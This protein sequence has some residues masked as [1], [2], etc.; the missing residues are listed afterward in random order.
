MITVILK[1][2]ICVFY[3]L[4]LVIFHMT[5]NFLIQKCIFRFLRLFGL[6]QVSPGLNKQTQKSIYLFEKMLVHYGM[7]DNSSRYYVLVIV[8]IILNRLTSANLKKRHLIFRIFQ[9][10]FYQPTYNQKIKRKKSR[11]SMDEP[12]LIKPQNNCFGWTRN[13]GRLITDLPC[14]VGQQNS[15]R[16]FVHSFCYL[17]PCRIYADHML[18]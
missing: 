2:V 3:I 14:V 15:F 13:Q 6:G 12:W 1:N 4:T 11:Q 8:M 10:S 9:A 17:K 7:L 16:V 5:K 18:F